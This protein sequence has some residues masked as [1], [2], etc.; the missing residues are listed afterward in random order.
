M[1]AKVIFCFLSIY[2]CLDTQ[3]QVPSSVPAPSAS[4]VPYGNNKAAGH[5]LDTRGFKMYY[6]TYGQGA[7]LLMLHMNGES[8]K[9]FPNQIPYFSKHYHVIAT[10]TRPHATSTAT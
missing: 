7:P 2:F 1:S 6:E 10:S 4:Q 5:Y 8:I 3:A 9:V